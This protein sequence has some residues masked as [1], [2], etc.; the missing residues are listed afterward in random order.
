MANLQNHA[1]DDL[2][3]TPAT[4]CLKVFIQ[5]DYSEGTNVKFQT[6]FP[7]ELED[8]VDKATFE[9]TISKLNSYY[10][11][12]EKATAATCCESCFACLTAYLAYLCMETQYEKL[13]KRIARY[14]D[15]QNKDVY[16]PKGLLIT[17]PIERGLRV[18]EIAVLNEPATNRT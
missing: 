2:P 9:E 7:T 4:G 8:R 16:I 3:R 15:K 11:E 13:L 17:N 5:R 14:I 6:K 18:I 10:A 1:M 12:A